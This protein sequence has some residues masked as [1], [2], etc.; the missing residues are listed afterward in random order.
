MRKIILYI[1]ASLNGKIARPDG[2]VDWLEAIPNPEQTDHGYAEFYEGIDTTL[3][4]N[5]L[6]LNARLI[7]EMWVFVMPVIVPEGIDLFEG[8]PAETALVL[9]ASRPYSSGAVLLQYEMG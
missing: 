1:A 3:Q 6:L 8:L 2:S 4:V 9:K 7:D 5:T